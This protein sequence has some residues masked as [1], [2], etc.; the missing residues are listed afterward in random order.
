[1]QRSSA[2]RFRCCSYL[3]AVAETSFCFPAGGHARH[4][5]EQVLSGAPAS[6]AELEGLTAGT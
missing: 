5:W 4:W 1:M 6:A 3:P 2:V